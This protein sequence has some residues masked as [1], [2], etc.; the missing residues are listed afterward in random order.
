LGRGRSAVID[1]FTAVTLDGRPTT[2]RR[3]DKGHRAEVE[4]FRRALSTG[5]SVPS[6]LRSTRTALEAAAALLRPGPDDE[7]GAEPVP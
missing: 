6:G 5:R 1:D 3:F 2:A 7:V 4:A